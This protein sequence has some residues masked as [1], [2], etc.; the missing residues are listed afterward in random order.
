MKTER[1]FYIIP[2]RST[3]AAMRAEKLAK[4]RF[5]VRV[6][7]TPRELSSGCGASLRIQPATE[8]ELVDFWKSSQLSGTL[9]KMKNERINGRHPTEEIAQF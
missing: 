6:V 4:D 3:T 7:N 8:E 5:A 2:F 1:Y 9:Y